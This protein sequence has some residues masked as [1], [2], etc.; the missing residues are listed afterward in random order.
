MSFH[1]QVSEEKSGKS[2]PYGPWQRRDV[3]VC[4]SSDNKITVKMWGQHANTIKS[5]DLGK[6]FKFNNTEVNIFGTQTSVQ[7]VNITTVQEPTKDINGIITIAG[8]Y[9]TQDG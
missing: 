3:V 6:T 5:H 8:A 4:D 2:K 1:F 7:T 9:S